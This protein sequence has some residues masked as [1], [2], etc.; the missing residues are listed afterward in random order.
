MKG[1]G[2]EEIESGMR[3]G[4]RGNRSLTDVLLVSVKIKFREYKI[5]NNE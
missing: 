2:R 1:G 4:E 3:E 5:K